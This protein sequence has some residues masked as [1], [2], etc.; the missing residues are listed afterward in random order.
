MNYETTLTA[1]DVL[2]DVELWLIKQDLLPSINSVYGLHGQDVAIYEKI[3]D[4]INEDHAYW[5]NCSKWSLF[6]YAKDQ[7]LK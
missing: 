7:V 2:D 5:A 6:N 4:L 1:A 3:E